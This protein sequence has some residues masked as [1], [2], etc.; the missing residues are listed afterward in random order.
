MKRPVQQDWL[1]NAWYTTAHKL[2]Q[3]A[4]MDCASGRFLET[5]TVLYD[6]HGS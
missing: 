2:L 3:R 5:V 1:S 6:A 4:A